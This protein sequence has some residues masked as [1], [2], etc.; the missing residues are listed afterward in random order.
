MSIRK[1]LIWSNIAMIVIPI[2]GFFVIEIVLGITLFGGTGF[3]G[4]DGD[5]SAQYA[6]RF[7]VF[8]PLRYV[9]LLLLV[10]VTNGLLTYVV[11]NS[12]QKP[13]RK[14][15]EAAEKISRGELDFTVE[16]GGKDELGQLSRVFELMRQRLKESAE[17]QRKYE[18]N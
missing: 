6:E 11:S 10:V 18:E 4:T 13:V 3:E 14:L 7:E 12:I 8:L 2:I 1:R 5:H 9:G 16:T 17:L 15:S